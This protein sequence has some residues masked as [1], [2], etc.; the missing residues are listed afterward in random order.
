MHICVCVW[1]SSCSIVCTHVCVFV[2]TC[3]TVYMCICIWR[4]ICVTLWP[5]VCMYVQEGPILPHCNGHV[6]VWEG[7]CVPQYTC[8]RVCA[9]MCMCVYIKVVLCH[10]LYTE[11]PGTPQASLLTFHP[12]S[13]LWT[14]P[15]FLLFAGAFGDKVAWQL[16]GL[17]D[18]SGSTR[19]P[20]GPDLPGFL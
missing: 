3:A 17:L 19:I 2:H 8:V 16:L 13:P 7:T 1:V 15:I 10:S 6:C 9:A 4:S 5:C 14:M 11:V 12:A 18:L 20:T